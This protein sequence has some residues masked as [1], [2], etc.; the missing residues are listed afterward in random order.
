MINNNLK[1]L[2]MKKSAPFL[3]AMIAIVIIMLSNKSNATLVNKEASN[4]V[5]ISSFKNVLIVDTIPSKMRAVDG[6]GNP[7][8]PGTRW[9]AARKKII[10]RRT[11]REYV[12][13]KNVTTAET[14]KGT[15]ADKSTKSKTSNGLENDRIDKNTIEVK[16][17]K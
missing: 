2:N 14:V 7:L 5:D 1:N 13:P 6:D 17:I 4:I 16:D 3:T 10:V 12:A 8:P 9:D 15:T 11:G